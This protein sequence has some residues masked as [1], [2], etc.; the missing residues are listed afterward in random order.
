MML[1]NVPDYFQGQI[2]HGVCN[3]NSY[4]GPGNLVKKKEIL[5]L[6]IDCL[7]LFRCRRSVCL[8]HLLS[9]FLV[10]SLSLF[11]VSLFTHTFEHTRTHA[12]THTHGRLNTHTHAPVDTPLNTREHTVEQRHRHTTLNMNT[13]TLET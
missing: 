3:S 6:V 11:V 9:L 4:V 12:H 5:Y 8:S 13:Q 2:Y 7:S 1:C 10:V